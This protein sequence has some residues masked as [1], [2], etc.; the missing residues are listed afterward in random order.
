MLE[1]NIS[2]DRAN[3]CDQWLLAEY[4]DGSHGVY[5]SFRYLA[6]KWQLIK[7]AEKR[8]ANGCNNEYI[9]NCD[10]GSLIVS[11]TCR[12][13][14]VEEQVRCFGPLHLGCFSNRR[15]D[16][17]E[18]ERLTIFL[19]TGTRR[20]LSSGHIR[21]WPADPLKGID[22]EIPPFVDPYFKKMETGCYCCKKDYGLFDILFENPFSKVN[23]RR[24]AMQKDQVTGTTQCMLA[25][26]FVGKGL[27][28]EHPVDSTLAGVL[29]MLPEFA[30]S[31]ADLM[32]GTM[33]SH[34]ACA[35]TCPMRSAKFEQNAY[36]FLKIL[37]TQD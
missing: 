1:A 10:E 37:N 25:W 15:I 24:E 14:V 29:L 34:I 19:P 12:D 27:H 3:M 6:A 36:S 35:A 2:S 11:T 28:H 30:V 4:D 22:L 16:V 8:L 33:A 18:G 5:G 26:R 20:E 17:R 32:T 31:I 7:V 21:F 23:G 9:T 13:G